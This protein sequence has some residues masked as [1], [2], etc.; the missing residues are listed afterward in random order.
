MKIRMKFE[1]ETKRFVRYTEGKED[2]RDATIGNLYI[3]K[4][5]LKGIPEE[6]EV[7]IEEVK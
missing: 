1:K 7:T 6:I 3:S 5:A 4:K 2:L